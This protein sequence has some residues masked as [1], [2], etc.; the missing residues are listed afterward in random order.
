[1]ALCNAT[2]VYLLPQ[3]CFFSPSFS[4]AGH[5]QRWKY[6]GARKT[7]LIAA[8]LDY[9]LA[10]NILNQKNLPRWKAAALR[11]AHNSRV[12]ASQRW[13]R[14][15]KHLG[16]SSRAPCLLYNV[17]AIC[18]PVATKAA[19]VFF[20]SPSLTLCTDSQPRLLGRR[21]HQCVKTLTLATSKA[22]KS[23]ERKCFRKWNRCQGAGGL[24]SVALE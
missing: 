23:D 1:M 22:L 5:T 6:T 20:F 13:L 9:K 15:L 19:A 3:F 10:F 24:F 4:R 12:H 21:I 8:V 18:S 16:K 2:H 14:L 11:P 17:L 7:E